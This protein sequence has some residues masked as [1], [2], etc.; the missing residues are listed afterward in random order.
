[1]IRVKICGAF[2][3]ALALVMLALPTVAAAQS[4]LDAHCDGPRE[5]SF[6]SMGGGTS[7]VAQ[8]FRAGITGSLTAAS[9]D[10]TKSG[11]AGDYRLDVNEV[12]EAGVPT[13]NVLAS[14]TISDASVPPGNSQP[15]GVFEFPAQVTAGQQYAL[16]LT[17]PG[18]SGLGWG[19]RLENDCPGGMYFSNTQTAP[20]NFLGVSYDVVFAVYVLESSAP[21]TRIAKG[22][23]DKTRRKRATFEFTATDTRVVAGFECSLD[24]AA[25]AACTSPHTVKVKK[26]KHSFAVRAVD[27]AGNVDGSPATFDWKRK[28]KRR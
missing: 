8:T 25:F 3:I 21:E 2:A 5:M 26:G 13:N 18:S 1:V 23:K 16:I 20:F 17:R 19:T 28:R 15:E 4:E 10:V 12:D 27:A 14:T 9:V 11:T 24:G 6:A 22:P 7:R